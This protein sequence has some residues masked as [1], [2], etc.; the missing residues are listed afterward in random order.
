MKP[1][2]PRR[3]D[4]LWTWVH[5]PRLWS[6]AIAFLYAL[7]ALGGIATLIAP[8]RSIEG[9]IGSTMTTVWGAL[10]AFGG[11]VGIPAALRGLWDFER[12][13]LMAC[14]TGIAIY[15][16][17]V[18]IMAFTTTG[19]RV[20]QGALVLALGIITGMRYHV[21]RGARRDYRVD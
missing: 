17:T 18:W 4:R 11:L 5:E 3:I 20:T 21:I 8:V 16:T 7:A 15:V 14:V 19:N 9:Q 6:T 2:P 12:A 1:R 10:L 13:A